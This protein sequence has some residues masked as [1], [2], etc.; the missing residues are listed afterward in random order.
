MFGKKKSTV[1]QH[2]AEIKLFAP[3]ERAVSEQQPGVEFASSFIAMDMYRAYGVD[4]SEGQEPLGQMLLLKLGHA[5]EPL[6]AKNLQLGVN[7]V[8]GAYVEDGQIKPFRMEMK[9][10]QPELQR[11]E[12]S[13]PTSENGV[14][15]D[16]RVVGPQYNRL[17]I[18]LI[19][20]G[21]E[22]DVYQGMLD[23]IDTFLASRRQVTTTTPGSMSSETTT[24][25]PAL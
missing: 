18:S 19:D 16:A 13:D 14:S 5:D 24:P 23:E 20:Q 17:E 25:P 7:A 9:T 21:Q 2:P 11:L 10:H 22:P 12:R 8:F 4:K 1:S 6:T 15:V 3:H